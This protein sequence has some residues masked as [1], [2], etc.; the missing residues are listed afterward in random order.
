[1]TM[2]CTACGH[3]GADPFPGR[4][5]SNDGL[6]CPACGCWTYRRQAK[7]TRDGKGD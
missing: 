5:M 2:V 6:E 1:M 3:E 4:I 7:E